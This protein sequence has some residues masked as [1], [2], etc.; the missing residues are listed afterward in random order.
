VR[1]QLDRPAL[2][3]PGLRLVHGTRTALRRSSEAVIWESVDVQ[4]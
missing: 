4:G 2:A 3:T 1:V